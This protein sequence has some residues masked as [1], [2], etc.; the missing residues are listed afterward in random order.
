[1][2]VARGSAFF[3]GSSVCPSLQQK[4]AQ[5]CKRTKKLQ[6]NA[7]KTPEGPSIVIVD[8]L[9]L[10]GEKCLKV[11]SRKREANHKKKPCMPANHSTVGGTAQ[12]VHPPLMSL[13]AIKEV[14]LPYSKLRLLASDA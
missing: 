5:C 2:H 12:C 7:L 10:M 4:R 8:S 9:G 11:T 14:N 13:Q 6:T 1:M 3:R